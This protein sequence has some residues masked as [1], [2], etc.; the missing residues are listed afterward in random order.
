M[1]LHDHKAVRESKRIN[2]KPRH[3]VGPYDVQRL[4]LS[5]FRAFHHLRQGLTRSLGNAAPLLMEAVAL[6]TG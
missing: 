5:C 2:A 4:E 1:F 6:E 3:R